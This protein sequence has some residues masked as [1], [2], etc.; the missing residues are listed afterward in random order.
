MWA[1]TLTACLMTMAGEPDF[2]TCE[3]AVVPGYFQAE[4]DCKAA[5]FH[6]GRVQ[7]V[8]ILAGAWGMAHGGKPARVRIE[9]IE[10]A[11]EA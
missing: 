6:P 3:R 10:M 9:C 11:R 4:A 8:R 2:A 1:I 5:A 7:F